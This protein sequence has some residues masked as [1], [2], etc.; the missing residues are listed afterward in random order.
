MKKCHI[1]TKRRGS[2]TRIFTCGVGKAL[3]KTYI[4]EGM[5]MERREVAGRRG[6]RCKQLLDGFKDKR[7]FN[8]N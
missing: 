3:E 4:V 2:I 6:R 8:L 1:E 5:I 7:Q